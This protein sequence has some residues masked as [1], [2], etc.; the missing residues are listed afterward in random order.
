MGL[1][2][3]LDGCGYFANIG[4]RS[5]NFQSIA[6]HYT[7][8]AVLAHFLDGIHQ[9]NDIDYNIFYPQEMAIFFCL[10]HMQNLRI[11]WQARL[12]GDVV[13]MKDKSAL[14]VVISSG[15]GEGQVSESCDRGSKSSPFVKKKMRGNFFTSWET[16]SLKSVTFWSQRNSLCP[17]RNQTEDPC[18]TQDRTYGDRQQL[19]SRDPTEFHKLYLRAKQV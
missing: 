4:I 7:D 13:K 14:H 19:Q 16:T 12:W 2:A 18:S 17:T 9:L 6:C 3:G 10:N 1:R 15:S 11:T 5:R 8:C